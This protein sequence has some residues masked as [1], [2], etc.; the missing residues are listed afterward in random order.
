MANCQWL[1]VNEG[2]RGGG[3]VFSVQFSVFRGVVAGALTFCPSGFLAFCGSGLCSSDLCRPASF[4]RVDQQARVA[5]G[6]ED[7]PPAHGQVQGFARRGGLA[8]AHNL[9]RTRDVQHVDAAGKAPP[10]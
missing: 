5:S 10:P 2:F 3:G 7:E 9:P 6:Q 4:W 1:I 8:L